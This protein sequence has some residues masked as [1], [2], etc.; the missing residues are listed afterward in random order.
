L[1]YRLIEKPSFHERANKSL[2]DYG[3]T[4]LGGQRFRLVWG[5]SRFRYLVG[6]FRPLYRKGKEAV[7]EW[8]LEEWRPPENYGTRESWEAHKTYEGQPRLGPY[9]SHGDYEELYRLG[10]IQEPS[11]SQIK[12]LAIVAAQSAAMTTAQKLASWKADEERKAKELE[13]FMGDLVHDCWPTQRELDD[14]YAN[15]FRFE[16]QRRELETI[17]QHHWLVSGEQALQ[18][19]THYA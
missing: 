18:E 11:D 16:K 9:P 7:R 15:D 6:E 5:P 4:P 14:Y 8:I 12:F 19:M 3:T 13:S 2:K 10:D 17:R 1:E